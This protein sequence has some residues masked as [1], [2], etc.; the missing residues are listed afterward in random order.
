MSRG[1]LDKHGQ[2]LLLALF[3]LLHT[4]LATFTYPYNHYNC[5][6]PGIPEDGNRQGDEF[7]VNATVSFS[8]NSGHV[9][10]GSKS[11]TCEQGI[12]EAFWNDDA[13]VCIRKS[14][15]L[16]CI[17]TARIAIFPVSII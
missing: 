3:L 10:Y 2:L 17:P 14:N 4:S 9:L 13:P 6:D 15:I 5:E 1:R 7:T 16:C 8:C 12:Y 11:I